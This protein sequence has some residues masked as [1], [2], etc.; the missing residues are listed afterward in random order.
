MPVDF[1][2]KLNKENSHARMAMSEAMKIHRILRI[3]HKT[4][5]E[6]EKTIMEHIANS[7]TYTNDCD[8]CHGFVCQRCPRGVGVAL[9]A[10]NPVFKDF[11]YN[12]ERYT[13]LT[14]SYMMAIDVVIKI[15]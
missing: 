12:D 13:Y 6:C 11:V 3:A 15:R 2:S 9:M 1:V 5:M 4:C 14:K 7:A 10:I 8:D